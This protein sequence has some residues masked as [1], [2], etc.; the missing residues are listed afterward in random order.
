M[1]IL[2]NNIMQFFYVKTLSPLQNNQ[3]IPVFSFPWRVQNILSCVLSVTMTFKAVS[4][5]QRY[6]I[7]LEEVKRYPMMDFIFVVLQW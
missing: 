5:T 7:M 4:L 2:R 6:S 3:Y 1:N